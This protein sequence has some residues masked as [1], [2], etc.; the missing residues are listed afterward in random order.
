MLSAVILAGG[1]GKRMKSDKPKVLHKALDKELVKWV[2][3][4]ARKAGAG[5]LCVVVG[6][7]KEQVENCLG[8]SV[9]YAVQTEQ[10]GTGHAVIM[11]EEFLKNNK[12][13]VLVLY[14]DTPLIT[15]NTLK[16]LVN[17]HNENKN[18]CTLITAIVENPA[19]YGRIARD[20]G[21][22][23]LKIVE[24][25][26]CSEEQLKIKECNGGMYCFE[27]EDL[28]KA[29][30][31]LNCDNDQNEYYLTDVPEILKNKGLKVGTY[32]LEDNNE[33]FG[34]SDRIQLAAAA[35]LLRRREI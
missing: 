19:G 23:F 34:V 33:M 7:K 25:R 11:A 35:E 31:E 15:G 18:S 28:L 2:L 5:N 13:T 3:D 12:G 9:S 8:Q 14:G 20:T 32:I 21:G 26:D 16:K 30:K 1:E 6:H 27:S 17:V 4:A 22:G 10:K 24:H 29:L